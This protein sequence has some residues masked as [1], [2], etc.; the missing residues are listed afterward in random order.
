MG[1][2]KVPIYVSD[3]GIISVELNT[4]VDEPELGLEIDKTLFIHLKQ[5]KW[6]KGIYNEMLDV[7]SLVLDTVK[8]AGY[9]SVASIILKSQEKVNKFQGM[10]GLIKCAETDR[11][12]I[13]RLEL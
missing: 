1:N 6:N 3:W 8:E 9:T 4:T 2:T 10:F 13:Y 11:H 5:E 7:W 12:N